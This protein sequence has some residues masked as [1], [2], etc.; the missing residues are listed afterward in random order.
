MNEYN[1][2]PFPPPLSREEEQKL[3][4]RLS[5]D[6][7]AKNTLVYR[8]L[9]LVVHISKKFQNTGIAQEDLISVGTIGLIKAINTFSFDK[10]VRLA[11]YASRCISN[12]ILMLLRKNAKFSNVTSLEDI[13]NID[14]NG[15][16]FTLSDVIPDPSADRFYEICENREIIS[17][18]FTF[19][20][21]HLSH[22]ECLVFFYMIGELTQ[23]QI[24]DIMHLSRSSISKLQAKIR[25]KLYN[26]LKDPQV[27]SEKNFIFFVDEENCN[28]GFSKE[29]FAD[30]RKIF[31]QF[32]LAKKSTY[33]FI[34]HVSIE[35]FGKYFNIKMPLTSDTFICIS[36]L[37]DYLKNYY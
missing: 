14:K 30:F 35:D 33:P 28:I 19:V 2:N 4:E 27:L 5:Y 8:N 16:P 12:E 22:R 9:R 18:L 17:S 7:E 32:S 10:K 6:L 13:I 31:A 26:Y 3:L 23:K 21:N 24:A 1:Q 34:L 29:K 37:I 36:E 11:T 25:S 20:L 15:N